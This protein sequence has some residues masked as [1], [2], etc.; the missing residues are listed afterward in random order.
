MFLNKG[1]LVNSVP[2][3]LIDVCMSRHKCSSQASTEQTWMEASRCA[4]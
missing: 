4:I 3:T 1:L 2:P